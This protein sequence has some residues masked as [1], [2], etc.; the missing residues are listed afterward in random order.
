MRKTLC[1]YM[2][3]YLMQVRL[4]VKMMYWYRAHAIG[5]LVSSFCWSLLIVST[6]YLSTR[7]V[8]QV[9][10]YSAYELVALS[11]VQ[12]IFLGIFHAIISH[13][14]ERIPEL[15][16]KGKLDLILLRPVD[17]QFSVS[18]GQIALASLA[19]VILGIVFLIFLIQTG[20]LVAPSLGAIVG[21]AILICFSI[22]LFYS[23][24]FMV[25]TLLIWF[26]HM[27]NIVELLYNINV[28]TRYPYEFFRQVGFVF[29]LLVFPFAI[30][31]IV[32]LRVLL[33]RGDWTQV[34]ALCLLSIIFVICSRLFW[35]FALRH[36]T[37]A[38]G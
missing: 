15:I 31:L 21:F 37:S 8:K 30:S 12:V 7:N 6:V 35:L 38:S 23:V 2:R 4:A 25:T 28:V 34:I 18:F 19:R 17:S 3:I 36:Y 10:G 13:N 24:W 29:A 16:A 26:P 20:Q 9:L 33:G 27:D 11:G 1:H 14:I 22:A 32:P 5:T